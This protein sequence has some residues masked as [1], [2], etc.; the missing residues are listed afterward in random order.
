MCGPPVTSASALLPGERP[1]LNLHLCG[2][3]LVFE[4]L[5]ADGGKEVGT[6]ERG[7]G[8]TPDERHQ[9]WAK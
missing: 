9:P 6:N 7:H 3:A 5:R 2:T 4:A 8:R 1:F